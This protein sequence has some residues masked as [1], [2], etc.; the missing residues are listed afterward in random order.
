[1]FEF[2]FNHSLDVFHQA[3]WLFARDWSVWLLCIAIVIAL[4][5]IF[6]SLRSRQ[7]QLRDAPGS[8]TI[9]AFFQ[10][11]ALSTVLVMLWQP[12]LEVSSTA[13]EDNAISVL[14]DNSTSM[15]ALDD[16]VARDT[17]TDEAT[18]SDAVLGGKPPAESRLGQVLEAFSNEGVIET[19]EEQ[20]T[21]RF[22][23]FA[24][25]EDAV[26]V[27][28][29]NNGAVKAIESLQD[30]SSAGAR[31]PLFQELSK[32]MR[33]A[34]E[35]SPAGIVLVTDGGHNAR[36]VEN[37]WWRS[38]SALN[39]PVYVV[40]AGSKSLPGDVELAEVDIPGELIPGASVP[41]TLSLIYDLP[42]EIADTGVTAK[43]VVRLFSGDNLLLVEDVN[44]PADRKRIT[45]TSWLDLPEESLL[46]LRVELS[47]T[48]NASDGRRFK[49]RRMANNTRHRVL[50]LAG[51]PRRILYI[52]GEPRWEFKFMRRALSSFSGLELVSLLRTS[53]NKLYRQ[54][55]KDASEL[56]DGFPVTREALFAYDALI[57][58]SLEA[59]YLSPEQQRNIQDFVRVRGGT[60]LM[61]AGKNGLADGGWARSPVAQ[62]LPAGLDGAL[63]SFSRE[64]LFVTPTLLGK[65]TEWLALA[66]SQND[67]G[68]AW[69]GLP[70]VADFQRL[71]DIKPGAS[72]LLQTAGQAA[73]S[74][75]PVLLWQ[76]YGRGK[77]YVL[78]T[79]GTWRWQMGLPAEDQR[80]EAFWQGFMGELVA[81]VLTRLSVS[82]DQFEY[83]DSSTAR[84][85]V[86]TRDAEF[87]SDSLTTPVVNIYHPDGTDRTVAMQFDPSIA[88]RAVA[89]VDVQDVGAYRLEVNLEGDSD[90]SLTRWITRENN[91]A[92]D[93]GVRRND[94][95]LQRLASATGGAVLE[96]DEI[97]RLPELMNAGSSLLVRHSELPLWN[98]PILFLLI[99]A[100]KLT[101]W[102]MRWRTGRI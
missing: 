94:A 18:N 36:S 67:D 20:F 14:V 16:A 89:D 77:S 60:L 101:E 24:H 41:V 6:F 95:L 57:I 19:L 2:L 86:D 68:Q 26:E 102:I 9:V 73:G 59:A 83:L 8:L 37:A 58:G 1:M 76:R 52:E 7:I 82:T 55:V 78:A 62:A 88:G 63:P 72:V 23:Q 97:D 65:Q 91:R 13:P 12:I 32:E 98:M 34:G 28:S 51:K 30:L 38:I 74:A 21:L 15:W 64:R 75:E 71:G 69:D 46:E 54:G 61:L 48:L 44:L 40:A 29:N 35:R 56:Q 3:N 39:V 93:F 27:G 100:S 43:T 87:Q 31:T 42:E 85:T 45:H 79:S 92:E 53:P 5:A 49:D 25:Q 22:A 11:V 47:D 84:L 4:P 50:P 70:A 66:A 17:S 80:H 96:L 99:I 90:I 10:W 81:G 33:S